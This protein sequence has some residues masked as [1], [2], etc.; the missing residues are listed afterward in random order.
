MLILNRLQNLSARRLRDLPFL[1]L[2]KYAKQDPCHIDSAVT[3]LS[4]AIDDE[5]LWRQK[6]NTEE[7]TMIDSC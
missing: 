3:A 7:T 5:S 1:S 2:T 4:Q 6:Y